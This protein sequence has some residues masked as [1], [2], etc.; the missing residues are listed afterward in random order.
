MIKSVLNA[1]FKNVPFEIYTPG[2][3]FLGP[4]TDLDK[5]SAGEDV[6]RN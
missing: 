6:G 3:D 5:R 4:G 1:I 2:Y